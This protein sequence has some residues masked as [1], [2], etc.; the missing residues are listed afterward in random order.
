M[1]RL[2]MRNERHFVA[3]EESLATVATAEEESFAT[4][5]TAAVE[6][7][8]A[9]VAAAEAKEPL[10]TVATPRPDGRKCWL[11]RGAPCGVLQGCCSWKTSE[12]AG[13]TSP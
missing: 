4:V 9:T 11:A 8:L 3:V 12:G 5:A 13:F 7:S 1:R 6:E 2:Q 10:A